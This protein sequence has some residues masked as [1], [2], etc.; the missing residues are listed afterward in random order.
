MGTSPLGGRLGERVFDAR[1]SVA[2]DAT[3]ALRPASRPCDDEAVPSRRLS[4]IEGGVVASFFYDL[5]TAARAG[6]VSTGS[7]HRSL[8][9]QPVPSTSSIV[10][11]PGDTPFDAMLADIADGIV[12]ERLMGAEQGNTLSGDFSGNIVLGYRV[13]RGRI[14]GR[15]KDAVVSGNIY[16]ALAD[17]A[18]I[19]SERRWVGGVY[20]PPLYCRGLSVAAKGS[21]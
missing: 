15:V 4:L 3:L 11:A 2:D 20:C 1:L 7:G 12:V 14:V 13:E 8:A 16:R 18:A 19:G 5:H 9:G 10:I 21:P 6:A 17:I